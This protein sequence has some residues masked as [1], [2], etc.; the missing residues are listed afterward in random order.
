MTETPTDVFTLSRDEL[1][2]A[3]EAVL[4]ASGDPVSLERICEITGTEKETALE[5]FRKITDRYNEDPRSGIS[6]RRLENDYV[7]CT[8][9]EMKAILERFFRPRSRPPMSQA[10]YETLAVI[11]YNQPVTRAQVE[12]VRGVSSDSIISRLL[13]RGWIQ[14][15]GTLDAPGRPV[16]F[17]TTQQ[18]LMEFGI[19]S[20]AEMPAMDLM[21]YSTI[22]DLEKSLEEAAGGRDNRQVS[23]EHLPADPDYP[24]MGHL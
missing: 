9:P 1:P 17:E 13:E 2:A 18:F 24:D 4:F 23:I 19:E 14:E 16:L 5:A 20:V 10:T 21:M 15:C 7:M 11:A 12:S 22:R 6:V 8:K 3:L